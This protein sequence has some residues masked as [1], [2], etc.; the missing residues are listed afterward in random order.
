MRI[1]PPWPSFSLVMSKLDN[2]RLPSYHYTHLGRYHP[3]ARA[4]RRRLED[5]FMNLDVHIHTN[6]ELHP[7][8]PSIEPAPTQLHPLEGENA[9]LDNDVSSLE[10]DAPATNLIA[11]PA[12]VDL[13][14]DQPSEPEPEPE[15]QHELGRGKL[16]ASLAEL[17]R[18]LRRQLTLGPLNLMFKGVRGDEQLK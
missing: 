12:R 5:T 18:A 3:Y 8:T 11:P 14:R 2:S 16:A 17:L 4:T 7:V 10:L 13:G 6:V 15:P 1:D 9:V